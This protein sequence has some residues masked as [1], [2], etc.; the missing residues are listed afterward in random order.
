MANRSE[1][2]VIAELKAIPGHGE[3]LRRVLQEA[4]LPTRSEVGN[5][6]YQLHEDR[7]DSNRFFFYERW[8]DQAAFN[9]HMNSAHAN[10]L[11][12]KAG[13]LLAAPPQ[14][15]QLRALTD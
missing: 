7:S 14:I 9:A 13:P 1:I 2:I 12:E 4:I 15:A 3:A 6:F 8:Q 10:R 5:D 11:V